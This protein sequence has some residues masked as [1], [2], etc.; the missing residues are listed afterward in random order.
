[1]LGSLTGRRFPFDRRSQIDLHRA[2]GGVDAGPHHLVAHVAH[3]AGAQVADAALADP[4]DAG[5][6]DAHAAAVWQVETSILAGLEDRCAGRALGLHVAAGE[7]DGA[8]LAAG[9]RTADL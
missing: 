8:A 4:S 7:P 6:A 5:V 2:L 3:L 1:M 9:I